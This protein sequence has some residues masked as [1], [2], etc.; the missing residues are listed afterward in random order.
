MARLINSRRLPNTVRSANIKFKKFHADEE[1]YILGTGP[2]ISRHDLSP[3]RSKI[4]FAVGEFFLHPLYEEIS[5]TYY[6]QAPNHEPFGEGYAINLVNNIF[7]GNV[8]PVTFLGHT[9]YKYS[10]YFIRDRFLVSGKLNYIDYTYANSLSEFEYL[11]LDEWDI[12]KTPFACNTAIFMAIQVAIYMGFK[13]IYLLGCDHDYILNKLT[14]TSYDQHHFYQEKD[15]A[16]D[17][18]SKY[19]SDYSLYKWFS[20]YKDRWYAYDLINK[21]AQSHKVDIFNCT[22]GGVLDVFP[23]LKLSCAL[24]SNKNPN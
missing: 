17:G 23:R 22:E 5:P 20:E 1:C 9:P 4:C 10:F 2:S 24:S 6:I 19:L 11:K 21:M 16:S 3:L 13:R 8:S 14:K 12:A 18:V 15:S 7:K